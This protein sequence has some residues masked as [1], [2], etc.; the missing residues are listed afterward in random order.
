MK[1][2][3]ILL[4]LVVVTETIKAQ[5]YATTDDG[6]R[7]IL[8]NDGTWE[9]SQSNNETPSSTYIYMGT[10]RLKAGFAETIHTE[11]YGA[12]TSLQLAKKGN[13]TMIIFWQEQTSDFNNWL[14]TGSV[15][16]YLENG[17]TIKL[18]DRNMKGQNTIKDGHESKSG[19]G[20]YSFTTK[21]DL[22]QRYSAYYLTASECK[23][24]EQSNISAI[25]Y[26]TTAPFENG[27]QNI[28]ISM[29]ANTCKTQL[30]AI[31]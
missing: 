24:L 19:Y 9:Y 29:N 17:E 25:S 1:N 11:S 10:D 2:L 13:Q 20:E 16:L 15:I 22:Y 27:R 18:L 28:R 6:K 7:V 30:R 3:I 8:N 12:E 21:S 4:L 23:Q 31:K 5:T 14:W 26:Q